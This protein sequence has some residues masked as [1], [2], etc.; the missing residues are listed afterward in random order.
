MVSK[1]I[2]VT[3]A[4]MMVKAKTPK[5]ESVGIV[6]LEAIKSNDVKS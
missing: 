4:Q 3:I 2:K 1:G 6:A 5:W